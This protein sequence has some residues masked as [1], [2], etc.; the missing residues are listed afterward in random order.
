LMESGMAKKRKSVKRTQAA[1]ARGRKPAAQGSAA[2]EGF[3]A[4]FLNLFGGPEA[5][6][7]KRKL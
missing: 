6:K 7:K 2:D 5:P 1:R 4:A 3:F